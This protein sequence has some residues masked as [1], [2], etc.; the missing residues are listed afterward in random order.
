MPKV[1]ENVRPNV[2][3][4]MKDGEVALLFNTTEGAQSLADS[5]GIR[6]A[7][8]TGRIPYYTTIAASLATAKAIRNRRESAIEVNA[9]QNY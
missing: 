5:K 4:K 2:V 8:L 6:A 9:L 7:A 1:Y 3:D